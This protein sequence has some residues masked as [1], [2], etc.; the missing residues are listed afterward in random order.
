MR[1][2]GLEGLVVSLHQPIAM[3]GGIKALTAMTFDFVADALR[4]DG[5][6]DTDL[7]AISRQLRSCMEDPRTLHGGPRIFQCRGRVPG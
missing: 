4:E 3:E 6:P 5:V 7:Q 1:E 2:A